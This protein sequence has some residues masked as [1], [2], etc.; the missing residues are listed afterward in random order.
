MMDDQFET[1]VSA[2]RFGRNVQDNVRKFVQ[3]QL[4]VNITTMIFVIS[5]VIILGHSPFNVVQL[6]WINLVMDVLAAI[7]FSTETPAT[8]STSSDRVTSKD[9]II[10]KPMM[11]QILF[12]SLYQL[13]VMIL[14]LYVGPKVGGYEYNMFNTEMSVKIGDN[15][16]DSYRCL[17]QT[18]MFQ[19]FFM[20]NLFNMV[21]CRLV[22]PIPQPEPE[23]EDAEVLAEFRA[24]N[25]P[26][27]NIF[28]RP[29][30]NWWFWIVLFAE[31]NVQ[32]FMVGYKAVGNFF[33][34][35]P[36]SF[37]MHMTALGLGLG[38]WG[39]CALIKLTGPRLIAAMPEVGEDAEALERAR[40][41]S[42][43]ASRTF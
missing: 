4:T 1:L 37:S 39:I 6:L 7:A 35:T 41:F 29:F 30:G 28:T 16:Y 26:R 3:F 38:S 19:V 31:L 17:H 15:R 12:Q 9:R 33:N 20:M 21:N 25:R 11:R 32:F 43:K 8:E 5:T 22:D 18:F 24:N 42:T 23:G 40:G 2:I 27:F 13:I 14:C 10:T 36:L 34:T